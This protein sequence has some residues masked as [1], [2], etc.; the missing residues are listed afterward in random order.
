M[1]TA[2]R[3]PMETDQPTSM[4]KYCGSMYDGIK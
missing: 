4:F 3:M 2:K 1:Y